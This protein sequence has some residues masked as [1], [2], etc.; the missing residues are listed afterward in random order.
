MKL[1]AE[2]VAIILI[3]FCFTLGLGYLWGYSVGYA[4]GVVNS[5]PWKAVP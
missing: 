1:C 4:H 3:T 5:D 2:F